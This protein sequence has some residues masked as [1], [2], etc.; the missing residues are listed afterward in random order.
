MPKHRSSF[1]NKTNKTQ[2]KR[3]ERRFFVH[4]LFF[5]VGVWFCFIGKLP[6]FLV[7]TLVALEHECAHA[8]TA[9]K[10]GYRLNKIV[11]MPYGA[12]IDGDVQNLAFKDGAQVAL[13]GP[14]ANLLTAGFFVALWWLFPTAYAFTDVAC[15]ASL[16]IAAVNLLP[17]YPL[18]GGRILKNG[19]LSLSKNPNRRR[20]EKKIDGICRGITLSFASAFLTLFFL[21][22][23]QKRANY[24]LLLFGIFLL[25][26]AFSKGG[27]YEKIN[28]SFRASF[29]RGAEVRRVAIL[30]NCPV[31]KVLSFLSV[32][33]FLILEI[34]DEREN[35]LGEIS[36][37]QLAA[38]FEKSSVY[39]PIGE[40]LTLQNQ[41][42]EG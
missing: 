29:A 39:T 32:D 4:P 36:Q 8:F 28:L 17:A 25:V 10:L 24:T 7:S 21:F 23:C 19:L 26:S 13:A 15:Y 27:N 33:R 12:A 20:A 2:K 11:L 14:L 22:L 40:A 9:A 30:E 37:I 5:L 35:F 6:L 38:F 1:F 42:T 31:K 41:K 18:D 34:Y 3:R 16:S